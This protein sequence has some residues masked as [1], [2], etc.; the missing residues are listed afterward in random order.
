VAEAP[1][2]SDHKGMHFSVFGL[3]RV[4][5]VRPPRARRAESAAGP[6]LRLHGM[7]PWVFAYE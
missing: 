1:P 5:P 7:H 2:A 3:V 6:T 4:V